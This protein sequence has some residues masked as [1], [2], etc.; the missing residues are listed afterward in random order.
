MTTEPR[1]DCRSSFLAGLAAAL[2]ANG[3]WTMPIV[4]GVSGGCDSTALVR[5]LEH[6]APGD[7]H[8]RMIIAHA[9]H[10]LRAEA[11]YDR[12]FVSDLA[13]RL[14]MPFTARRIAV[15]EPDG[16]RD[17]L[18][19]RARRL[20]YDFLRD[21]ARDHGARYVLVA[22]TADDQAETI[23]HRALR[24]T[25]LTGLAGMRPTRALAPGIGLMRPMLRLPR[26]AAR[27][28]L[29]AIG[30]PW[31]EDASNA[32]TRYARNFLRH[33]VLRPCVA[34]P[35]P[36]A[37]AALGRLGELAA[38][39]AASVEAAALHLLETHGQR[40]ADG[41]VLVRAAG[42]ATLPRQLRAALFVTLW[43]REG[44]RE[45]DM[46]AG[47]YGRLADLLACSGLDPQAARPLHLPGGRRALPEPAGLLITALDKPAVLTP[48]RRP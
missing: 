27:D 8:R 46:T 43:R 33:A 12:A 15:R 34:G 47:H 2:P 24:G 48:H 19:A 41:G 35:Y 14:G 21:V 36:A 39:L 9:E 13:T 7:V 16:G 6:V 42:L 17:G 18:E 45:R 31:C 1:T 32:D 4:I 37:P 11:P 44:W 20:R 38:G 40:H 5:G 26:S 3:F 25:G 22:H 10:D 23:L 28:F 29:T 30:Q